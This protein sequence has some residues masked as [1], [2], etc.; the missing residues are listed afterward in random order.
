MGFTNALRPHEQKSKWLGHRIF[1]DELFRLNSS[2]FGGLIPPVEV[3]QFAVFIPQ[4]NLRI[5]EQTV[6][7]RAFDA[8]APDDAE[9]SAAL[10]AIPSGTVAFWT[11]DRA[12]VRIV[13]DPGP[14]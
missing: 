14:D 10:D 6:E 7:P 8:L 1:R 2:N 3:I 5:R 4:G 13:S 12:H 9:H 11:N